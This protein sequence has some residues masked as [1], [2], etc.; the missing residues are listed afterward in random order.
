[1]YAEIARRWEARPR[2]ETNEIDSEPRMEDNY[3][4]TRTQ[5]GDIYFAL[6]LQEPA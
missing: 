4:I 5:D 3:R 2:T 1:M 6:D